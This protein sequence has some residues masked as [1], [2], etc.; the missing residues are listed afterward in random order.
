MIT[1]FGE[2]GIDFRRMGELLDFQEQHGC[3]AV[4]ISGTTGESAA[5]E[6]HEYTEL[7]DFCVKYVSGR[8]KVI[9]SIG[10]NNT[11]RCLELA[12]ISEKAGA[13]AVIMTAPYYTK[14]TQRGI[15]EHFSYVADRTALP[16]I[17]YNIP[18]RAGIGISPESYSSLARHPNIN[19]VKEASGDFSL[20]SRL[21]SECGDSLNV[22][23]G[24]DDNTLPMMAMGA[25]GVFSV[26]SNLIPETVSILCSLCLNGDFSAA[27]ELHGR[28]SGFFSALFVE[29]NP[30]PIKAAMAIA[31]LDSGKLRLPLVG[32]SESGMEA[33]LDSMRRCGIVH[34]AF[35]DSQ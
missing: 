13:D 26:A 19:G 22:W 33:L 24:N 29:T 30:I 35:P 6:I 21:I 11:R 17:L 25:R 14:S 15:V 2:S 4:L 1:P 3:S 27:R 9:S 8:M 31:G 23:S 10:G 28:Y 12:Q 32:I 7:V 34:Q 5:L 20:I 16:L 18:G